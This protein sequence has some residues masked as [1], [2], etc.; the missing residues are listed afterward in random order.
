MELASL[1]SWVS[2]FLI[3]L[4]GFPALL[5]RIEPSHFFVAVNVVERNV[6]ISVG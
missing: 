6:L 2:F 4:N 1:P 3:L 5:I